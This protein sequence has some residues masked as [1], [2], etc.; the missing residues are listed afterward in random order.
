MTLTNIDRDTAI[1]RTTCKEVDLADLAANRRKYE[2]IF[3]EM[4]LLMKEHVGIGIAANQ[5]GYD[6]RMCI[7]AVTRTPLFMINPRII[8]LSGEKVQGLEGC[9]S[10]P[11]EQVMVKRSVTVTVEYF[12]LDGAKQKLRANGLTA[13]CIQHEIDHLN[14]VVIRDYR[15]QKTSTPPPTWPEK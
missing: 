4:A 11:D 10:C 5:A 14:G 8:F 6:L 2:D 15:K 13:R 3:A 1:L 9:L 7:V 12:D